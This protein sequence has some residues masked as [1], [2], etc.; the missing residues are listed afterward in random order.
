MDILNVHL[1]L[2]FGDLSIFVSFFF[3][4]PILPKYEFEFHSIYFINLLCF[5]K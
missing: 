3:L 4:S 1:V 2:K 5:K